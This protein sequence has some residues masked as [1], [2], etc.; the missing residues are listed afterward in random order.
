M[1][2]RHKFGSLALIYV[3]SLI[4]NVIL[5]A[6]CILAYHHATLEN[7]SGSQA[8]PDSV[9]IGTPEGASLGGT[10]VAPE[11]VREHESGI[12]QILLL[13]A[14]CGLALA[15]L[16][17]RLVKRWVSKPV[18]ALREAAT[19]IGQG[20]FAHRVPVASRD[21][22]GLLA[23]EVNHMAAT[24]VT[25]QDRLVEQERRLVA[26]QALRCIVHNIRSPLTGIRW[27]A[28]AIA[29]RKDVDAQSRDHQNR[30][31]RIVDDILA[32]LQG[33]RDFL[34]AASLQVKPVNI[35]AVFE[36]L[37]GSVADLAKERNIVIEQDPLASYE[38]CIDIGQARPALE[39]LL[40]C[41]LMCCACGQKAR[42]SAEK[43]ECPQRAWRLIISCGDY[44]PGPV[45]GTQS[46]S[47]RQS[48]LGHLDRG[49]L[50]M[51]ERAIQMHGGQLEIWDDRDRCRF[52]V[53]LPN[54]CE[55][56]Q[57]G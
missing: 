28:E 4:M 14:I 35:A 54:R 29:M 30:I 12:L 5:C 45:E 40:R 25:M 26:G 37:V 1:T 47:S 53:T 22:L 43:E 23:G 15:L 3:V 6:W 21:E 17:L 18:A 52:V 33:F 7:L 44:S 48:H 31:V 55:A 19:A 11:L 10:T 24:V 39:T 27:L 38:V 32:W 49:D 56:D 16:G 9:G 13:N 51:A 36:E 42:L 50:K 34:A 20:N 8:R 2:L 46:T 41:A 57:H